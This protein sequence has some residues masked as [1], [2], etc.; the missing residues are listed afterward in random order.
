MVLVWVV[1]IVVIVVMVVVMPNE[2]VHDHDEIL[3]CR[4][5]NELENLLDEDQI[6]LI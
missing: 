4:M 3:P 5:R 1:E 2:P 6:A